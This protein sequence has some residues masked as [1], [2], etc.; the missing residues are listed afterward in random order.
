[1][2]GRDPS[3]CPAHR[4]VVQTNLKRRSAGLAVLVAAVLLVAACGDDNGGTNAQAGSTTSAGGE[5]ST[6]TTEAPATGAA[7]PVSTASN[8]TL[9]RIL[10]DAKGMT[11]YVFDSDKD[12]KSACAGGCA[13]AWPPVVLEA[14]ASLPTTGDLAADLTTA[15]RTDGAQQVAYKGRP[16]YRF[17]ADTKPG[18]AKGDGQGGIWHVVKVDATGGATATTTPRVNPY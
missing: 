15:A 6:T 7:A 9:G 18:D 12:G 5:T 8:P 13:T 14:G 3:G 16:L 1:M 4:T 2:N 10:V 17:A 11:V